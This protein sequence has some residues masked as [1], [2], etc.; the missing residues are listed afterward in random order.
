ME[1]GNILVDEIL[2][3]GN[4]VAGKSGISK[5]KINFRYFHL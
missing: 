1:D 2:T 3:G 4:K 5:V